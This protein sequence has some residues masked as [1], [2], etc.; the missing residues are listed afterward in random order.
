MICTICFSLQRKDELGLRSEGRF[1]FVWNVFHILAVLCFQ[2][3][4]II[5]AHFSHV[6]VRSQTFLSMHVRPIERRWNI[7]AVWKFS[8]WIRV[9]ALTQSWHFKKL[10][11]ALKEPLELLIWTYLAARDL[12]WLTESDHV[13]SITCLSITLFSKNT[14]ILPGFH[15][16][17]YKLHSS[18]ITCL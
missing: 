12:T 11:I 9:K 10:L 1:S 14:T 13:L 17:S 8:F 16:F 5:S 4:D 15:F 6:C 18:N 2:V 3:S 7:E